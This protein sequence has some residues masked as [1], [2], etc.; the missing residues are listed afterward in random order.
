M[1]IQGLLLVSQGQKSHFSSRLQ[2]N[3][4]SVLVGSIGPILDGGVFFAPMLESTC[5]T[6]IQLFLATWFF[7]Q[8][9]PYTLNTFF[10]SLK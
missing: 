1:L 2:W 7:P 3:V 5:G 6:C 8:G 10:L 9:H 4:C